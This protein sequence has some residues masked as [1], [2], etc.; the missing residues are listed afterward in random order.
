MRRFFYAFTIVTLKH[1]AVFQ[2]LFQLVMSQLVTYYIVT[3]RPYLEELAN[4]FTITAVFLLNQGYLQTS[5]SMSR[6]QQED[7]GFAYIAVI[8][9]S[10]LFNAYFFCKNIVQ[11]LVMARLVPLVVR[12]KE[13]MFPKK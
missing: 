8:A 1:S 7:Y 4:E 6:R 11:N 5:A 12:L 2:G 10:L 9:F 3:Y 13:K